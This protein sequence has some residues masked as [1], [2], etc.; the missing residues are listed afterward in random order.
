MK[1]VVLIGIDSASWKIIDPFVKEG[2]LPNFKLLKEKGF[3]SVLLSTYPPISPPGW[4]SLFTGVEP[5]RHRIFDFIKRKKNSYFAEPIFSSDRKAPFIWEHLT[6][7]NKRTIAI[8]IPFAYPPAPLNGM[9]TT[10]LGTPSKD[11]E[12][13]CPKELKTYIIKK[14]PDFDVDFEE[15]NLTFPLDYNYIVNKVEKGTSSEFELAKDL[16]YK[17][18][19]DLFTVVFRSIDVIQHYFMNDR[20]ILIKFYRQ[21][22]DYIGWFIKNIT[23]DTHLIV[24]SDH[25]GN[26]VTT[27]FNINTWLYKNG[28]LHMKKKKIRFTLID[29]DR[30]ETFLLKTPLKSIVWKLKRSAIMEKLLKVTRFFMYSNLLGSYQDVDWN[31]TKMYSLVTSTG[32]IFI[33]QIRRE[34]NGTVEYTERFNLLKEFKARL[35]KLEHNGKKV[36]QDI[37]IIDEIY[38]QRSFRDIEIPDV[39]LIPNNG[40]S[41][42][43]T[44]SLDT[45]FTVENVRIGDHTMEGIVNIYTKNT[46]RTISHK[47]NSKIYRIYDIVPTVLKF[48]GVSVSYKF[49][50][51]PII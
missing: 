16:F 15:N 21:M 32:L 28:Y 34:P 43:P 51:R 49:D 47:L 31:N 20:N 11:S 41:I 19:W 7:K 36:L 17:E 44:F 1:K 2:Y 24:C 38:K 37:I 42:H 40:F 48:M 13:T 26:T 35:S 50:G 23:D 30:L 10:G 12:F 8:G 14:Y 33:N 6:K 18:N 5:L 3:S 27:R 29:T 25:G 45:I 39:I 46:S 9:I 4:I 22:D